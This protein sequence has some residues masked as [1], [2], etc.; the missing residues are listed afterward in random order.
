MTKYDLAF[1]SAVA[2]FDF[3]AAHAAMVANNW[4]W[5]GSHEPPSID[6]LIENVVSLW[7]DVAKSGGGSMG[8]GGFVVGINE[9]DCV[10]I[11]FELSVSES[12][13]G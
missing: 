1:S 8:T 7:S 13:D 6:L 12:V 10:Y 11:S 3:K 4:T 2:K 9:D 5:R